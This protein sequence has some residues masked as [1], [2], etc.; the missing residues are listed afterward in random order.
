MKFVQ[1]FGL[2]LSLTL[3]LADSEL[4]NKEVSF[5]ES[6]ITWNYFS[7]SSYFFLCFIS[8]ETRITNAPRANLGQFPWHALLAIQYHNDNTNQVVFWN[9]V[10]LNHLWIVTTAD[11]VSNAQ[12][13]RADIG[14]VHINRPTLRLFP[15]WYIVHPQYNADRFVNNLGLVRMPLNHPITF[16]SGPN[17]SHFPIRLPTL[18]QQYA[19]FEGA[20][21]FFS[22]WGL[23]R[24]SEYDVF[25]IQVRSTKRLKVFDFFRW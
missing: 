17:P 25:D 3:I 20:E 9:G 10:I 19:T 16:P 2:L 8:S 6:K 4:K 5:E 23:D 12:T 24:P 21:A 13:I 22:G 15:N 18:R 7:I 1:I 11:S 14:H